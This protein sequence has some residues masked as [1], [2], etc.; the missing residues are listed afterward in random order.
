MLVPHLLVALVVQQPALL[1]GLLNHS[2]LLI[3]FMFWPGR[4]EMDRFQI[5]GRLF[6]LFRI[7][8]QYFV[9]IGKLALDAALLNKLH[10]LHSISSLLCLVDLHALDDILTH[11]VKLHR[12]HFML[13][14]VFWLRA[15]LLLA[16]HQSALMK[17]PSV[18]RLT[19]AVGPYRLLLRVVFRG[20]AWSR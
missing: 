20:T 17:R 12:R 13:T 4:R 18:R 7:Q 6:G 2:Q 14:K 3:P 8:K 19:A 1:F 15:F 9:F 16:E 5:L 10:V 11:F